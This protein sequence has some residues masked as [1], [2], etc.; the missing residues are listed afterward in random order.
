MTCVDV[1]VPC[2]RYGHFLRECVVKA[3]STS[4]VCKCPSTDYR[5]RLARQHRGSSRGSRYGRREGRLHPAHRE[6]GPHCHL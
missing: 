3:F 2:Y 5:R 4:P 6:Q 1:V